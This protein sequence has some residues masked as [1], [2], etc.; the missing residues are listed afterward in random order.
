VI[1]SLVRLYKNGGR[2]REFALDFA[3][4]FNPSRQPHSADWQI[5]DGHWI[6][7][8]GKILKSDQIPPRMRSSEALR[9]AEEYAIAH[10]WT[11]AQLGRCPGCPTPIQ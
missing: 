7:C 3:G 9:L 4:S 6:D 8:N 11:M 5:A 2:E 10:L 1:R